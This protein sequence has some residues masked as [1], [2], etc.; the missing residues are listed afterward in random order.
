MVLKFF[1]GKGESYTTSSECVPAVGSF[2]LLHSNNYVV[3]SIR[4][5]YDKSNHPVEVYLVKKERPIL[6]TLMASQYET[7]LNNSKDIQ[8]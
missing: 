1:L 4:H 3:S 7:L 8:A 2:V 5:N 6:D